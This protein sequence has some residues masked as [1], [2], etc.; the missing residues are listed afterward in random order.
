MGSRADFYRG[1]GSE[2]TWIGSLGWAGAPWLLPTTPVLSEEEYL[3]EVNLLMERRLDATD[4]KN[5]WPWIYPDSTLTPFAYTFFGGKTHVAILG[6]HWIVASTIARDED[7]ILREE[8]EKDYKNLWPS[9][10]AIRN[11]VFDLRSGCVVYNKKKNTAENVP[12]EYAH[13]S[14]DDF[15]RMDDL[16]FWRTSV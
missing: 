10:A 5:G 16:G 15:Q 1:V 4:T 8:V 6:G 14:T 3:K 12:E 11:P 2:L 9:Q 7:P 13:Y